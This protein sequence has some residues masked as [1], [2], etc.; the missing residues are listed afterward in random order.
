M[1]VRHIASAL[2][3]LFALTMPASQLLAGEHDASKDPCTACSQKGDKLARTNPNLKRVPETGKRRTSSASST[4]TLKRRSKPRTNLWSAYQ[5]RQAGLF[6]QLWPSFTGRKS[7]P[8]TPQPQRARKAVAKSTVAKSKTSRKTAA[9]P[10]ILIPYAAGETHPVHVTQIPSFSETLTPVR[11]DAVPAISAAS[12]KNH[13]TITHYWGAV[14]AS[15]SDVCDSSASPRLLHQTTANQAVPRPLTTTPGGP[16]GSLTKIAWSTEVTTETK[17]KAAPA[18]KPIGT[19]ETKREGERK[20]PTETPAEA[21]RLLT[22]GVAAPL[23]QPTG[24]Q[25]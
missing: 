9:E 17:P 13:H 12:S 3:C 11:D 4:A 5:N 25:N 18:A 16:K 7:K 1:K 10:K 15:I 2:I 21:P 19:S 23:Q 22:P 20:T 24:D 8:T 14:R 6:S